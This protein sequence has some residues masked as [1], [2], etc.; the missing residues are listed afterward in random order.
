MLHPSRD[1]PTR[2]SHIHTW[3]PR[4]ARQAFATLQSEYTPTAIRTCRRQSHRVGFRVATEARGRGRDGLQAGHECRLTPIG[5]G[6]AL[7][8]AGRVPAIL[9]NPISIVTREARL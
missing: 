6:F 8:R 9:G 5:Q 3:H 7:D 2:D 1:Q 4:W